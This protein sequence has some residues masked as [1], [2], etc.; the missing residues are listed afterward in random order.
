MEL[1]ELQKMLE[2]AEKI[3]NALDNKE[4]LFLD[5][6]LE[7]ECYFCRDHLQRHKI[8]YSKR[9]DSSKE[10]CGTCP[11]FLKELCAW[12]STDRTPFRVLDNFNYQLTDNQDPN[13]LEIQTV[14][15]AANQIIEGIKE[16]IE[17]EYPNESI[18]NTQQS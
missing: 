17:E 8:G 9:A 6:A 18:N 12:L 5:E 1:H 3:L 16:I 15:L 13:F 10:I 2:K 14:M 11:L 4:W 7:E